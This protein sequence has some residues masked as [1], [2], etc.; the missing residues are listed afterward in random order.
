MGGEGWPDDEPTVASM[1]GHNV[2]DVSDIDLLRDQIEAAKQGAEVYETI[3]SNDMAG[4]AQSLR[5]R[6]NELAGNVDKKREELKAPH[7]KAGKAIDAEWMP[8]VKEA[9]G[10]A[11]WLAKAIGAFRDR[12]RLE[13]QRLELERQR[14]EAAR[15]REEEQARETA[16]AA[17]EAG[18]PVVIPPAPEPLPP[19]PPPPDD[20]VK[21][22]Y[23]RA[24]HV[25]TVRVVTA[26]TDQDALYSSLREHPDLRAC[27]LDLAQRAL[28]AGHEPPG[29][30]I[31]ER[32][33]VS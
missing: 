27:L 13:R 17:L 22:N 26:I 1:I 18:R 33:K 31:E 6:M 4:K 11:D 32:A 28:R 7:L 25:A 20:R 19:L 21:G 9:K 3:D 16:R 15:Q 12:Q 29:V 8:L 30:T 14:E 24:A 23:G 2:G 10:V 5:A